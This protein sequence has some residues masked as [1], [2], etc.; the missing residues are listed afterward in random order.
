V[1]A[2]S[3]PPGSPRHL[4]ALGGAGGCA[5]I[6]RSQ[7]GRVR[8]SLLGCSDWATASIQ[9]QRVIASLLRCPEEPAMAGLTF[10]SSLTRK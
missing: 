4:D 6:E 1:T 7:R 8:A 9:R 2:R 10:I 3:R 5:G